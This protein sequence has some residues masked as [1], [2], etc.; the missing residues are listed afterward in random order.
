[1]KIESLSVENEQTF[2]REQAEVTPQPT[3]EIT[4]LPP[5]CFHL[6]GGGESINVLG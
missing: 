2:S 5:E 1:M 6:V 4:P 3:A